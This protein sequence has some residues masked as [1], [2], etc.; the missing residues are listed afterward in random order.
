MSNS[1]TD[2]ETVVILVKFGATC[3]FI[4]FSSLLVAAAWSKRSWLILIMVVG[5]W[6][7]TFT[8]I[9]KNKKLKGEQDNK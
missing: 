1:M 9:K 6:V 2:T 8:Q 4:V 3:G 5:I 7:I